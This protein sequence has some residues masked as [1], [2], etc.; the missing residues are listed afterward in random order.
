MSFGRIPYGHQ[1]YNDVVQ[2][3]EKGYRLPCPQDM[4]EV[5]TWSPL[6]LYDELAKV[7]FI[8]DP[9]ERATFSDV[10]KII[11]KELS[12][13]EMLNYERMTEEYQCSRMSNYLNIGEH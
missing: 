8:G 2:Q 12:A 4:K 7:C 9:D 11:E 1:E 3:I 10:A 5:K 13:K 6:V